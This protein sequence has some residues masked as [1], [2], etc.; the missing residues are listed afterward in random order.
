MTPEKRY[1]DRYGHESNSTPGMIIRM[2][3]VTAIVGAAMLAGVVW[4]IVRLVS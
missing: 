1:V 3:I 4:A 2:L